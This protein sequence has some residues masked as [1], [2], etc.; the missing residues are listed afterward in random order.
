MVS[1]VELVPNPRNPNQHDDRQIKLLA[2]IIAHQ[3]WRAPITVSKRSGFIVTGHG[4]MQAAR[5]LGLDKVPVDYQDF[6]T[7]ADEWAHLVADNRIAELA[8]ID[9]QDLTELLSEI[10]T[11]LDLDIA[12][13]DA[14]GLE[15]LGFGREDSEKIDA[16]PKVDEKDELQKKWKTELGQRWCCGKHILVCG[17]STNQTD[18]TYLLGGVAPNLMVTDPPYG[19]EYDPSW[20]SAAGKGRRSEGKVSNDDRADWQEAW[21]LF[22]GAV[23][24]VWHGGLHSG[25]VLD[26]LVKSKFKPRAQIIWAKQHFAVSRGDYHWQHE[27]CWYAVR[28]SAT[29]KG[30]RKQTTVWNIA[31]HCAFGGGGKDE[32]KT[33]HGTE[34]PVECMRRPIENNSSPGQAVYDPFLGSGAT[35][36]AAEQAGRVCY[37][38]ELDPGYVA[39]ILERYLD[40]TGENPKLERDNN[41]KTRSKAKA[42]GDKAAKRKPGAPSAKQE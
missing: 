27:P 21:D 3:G 5:Y 2:K 41:G 23:A 9:K 28:G 25:T 29:W 39:V 36:I 40:A 1:L 34:K 11:D 24:Y 22:P 16:A 35:M 17:D 26:S 4:R 38:M 7:E 18:V 31:N 8:E 20:R 19:V 37:G 13:F 33:A 12:G 32:K 42:N 6:K 30:D 14:E 15:D 10:Q